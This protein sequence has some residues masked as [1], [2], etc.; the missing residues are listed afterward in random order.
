[1]SPCSLHRNFADTAARPN[2]AVRVT[3]SV[4]SFAFRNA[5]SNSPDDPILFPSTCRAGNLKVNSF[6]SNGHGVNR[7]FRGPIDVTFTSAVPPPLGGSG[8]N[9]SAGAENATHVSSERLS[10]ACNNLK[11]SRIVRSSFSIS[12]SEPSLAI[13]ARNSA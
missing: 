8:C 4:S 6:S 1:M 13:A 10:H 9:K 3:V 7:K 2:Y 12:A 11:C 5:A